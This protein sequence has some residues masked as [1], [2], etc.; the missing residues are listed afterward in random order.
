[1]QKLIRVHQSISL[2]LSPLLAFLTSAIE[3]L[4]LPIL[5]SLP[6]L[7]LL[8]SHVEA[9][10]ALMQARL[11][12]VQQPFIKEKV[13]DGIVKNIAELLSDN[14]CTQEHRWWP[15]PPMNHY[16]RLVLRV[17]REGSAITNSDSDFEATYLLGPTIRELV[18]DLDKS[19]GNSKDW[20]LQL[21][22]GGQ[23]VLPLSLYQS[24]DCMSV[25]L[26]LEG[27]CVLSNASITNERQR[28]SW[29]NEGEGLVE[30]SY[31]VPGSKNENWEFDERLRFFE[32]GDEPLVVVPLATE[33]LL[34]LVSSHVKEIGCKESGD[35]CQLSQ[36]VTNRIKAFK[37]FVDTSLEGGDFNVVR[38]PF[39]R[40]GSNSFTAAMREFSNF[41]SEQ[42]L[43]DLPL[44]G[45]T[46]TWLN[47]REVASKARLDRFLFLQIGRI[48]FLQFPKDGCLGFARIIF[49]LSLRVDLSREGVGRL[50]LRICGLR[51]RVLWIGFDLDRIKKL[52]KDLSVLENMEDSRGLSAEETVEVGSISD[53]LE[54]ATLL[55]EI[56]WRQKSR[57]LCVREGDRNTKIF[58]RIANSHRRVNSIDR[59]MM[60]WELSSDPT[61]IADCIS[62]FYR[63]LYFEDVAHKLVLDDVD[64]SS[65]SVED[66]SWLDRPF[67]EEEVFG[68]INDFNG[69]KAPSS[70][71]FSMAFFQFCWC[72]L[73]IKIMAVFHNFHT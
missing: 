14:S 7:N 54:K 34:E 32:R 40:L 66:A 35:N 43:I 10:K 49:Q 3:P 58:H 4:T 31:V 41:I 9:T 67:E 26:S 22:D 15:K 61:A 70:D 8:R 45:G 17:G 5:W 13:K 60:D 47:S 52:W 44:Q 23:I 55:E 73:K 63:Q 1:M 39:E 57:V 38:F 29:A 59:L 48:S 65:I 30:S 27:E 42:G 68:V 56:C 50:D 62:Q 24:P 64:F 51:M 25:C 6:Q 18:E 20:I 69:D 36:W 53:E 12:P 28:G 46:F 21:R 72:V 19:W 37:K 11:K 2:S 16:Q 71:G 33:G